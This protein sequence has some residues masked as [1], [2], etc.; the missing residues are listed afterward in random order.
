MVLRLRLRLRLRLSRHVAVVTRPSHGHSNLSAVTDAIWSRWKQ[1]GPQA[2]PLSA[3]AGPSANLNSSASRPGLSGPP[4]A[5][6]VAWEGSGGSVAR[7]EGPS[8]STDHS[9]AEGAEGAA[10]VSRY[11]GASAS[12]LV[13]AGSV[14][15]SSSKALQGRLGERGYLEKGHLGTWRGTPE[16]KQKEPHLGSTLY[17]CCG[18]LHLISQCTPCVAFSWLCGSVVC[19]YAMGKCDVELPPRVSYLDSSHPPAPS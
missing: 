14:L 2:G 4:Q 9:S 17:W 7:M 8:R 13:A 16:I 5:V 1:C 11:T 19:H 12:W 18:C 6:Q 15:V 10:A 3:T